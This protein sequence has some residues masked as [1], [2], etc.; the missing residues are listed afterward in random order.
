MGK[1]R[2]EVERLIRLLPDPQGETAGL[3]PTTYQYPGTNGTTQYGYRLESG[4]SGGGVDG[5]IAI[6]FG[7]EPGTTAPIISTQIKTFQSPA[8]YNLTDWQVFVF[9]AATISMDVRVV[10]FGATLPVSGDSI[11]AGHPITT[12]AT[13]TNTGNTSL[14]GS[15]AIARGDWISIVITANDLAKFISLE[16]QG[17]KT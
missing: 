16:L 7:P 8:D 3:V 15:T 11:T 5:A 4:G 2:T 10:A 6:Q 13:Q 1:L 9:P 12:T 17:T 14:W